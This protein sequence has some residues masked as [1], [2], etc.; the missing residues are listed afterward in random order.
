MMIWHTGIL[1]IASWLVPQEQRAE[2]LAEWQGELWQLRRRKTDAAI[3][4]L[5][6]FRDAMWLW[7]NHPE[8][9][10]CRWPRLEAPS[11]CLFFLATVA[12]LSL[13]F[14]LRLPHIPDP[15]AG[16][17]FS[18]LPPLYNFFGL[19]TMACFVLPVTTSLSLGEYPA[20]RYWL[21]R[22]AFL[23]AKIA[24]VLAPIYSGC[25]YS[26]Y[27]Y[28]THQPSPIPGQFLLLGC[29]LAFRWILNDQRRRCPVC[30]QSLGHAAQVGQ[31]ARNF[32][33][34]NGTELMCKRG[35][36]LL[37]VPATP[38]DWSSRQR[39]LDLDASWSG[40]FPTTHSRSRIS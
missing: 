19:I 28:L 6:S 24:L 3:F 14:V 36:G 32:L 34:W 21:R 11:H 40:L 8:S 9:R 10:R 12:A 22:W 1:N 31:P 13:L 27:Q 18:P 23:A 33:E 20:S 2:W 37:H 17:R 30:L 39:W 4:C 5:G 7:R 25:V 26:K 38:S 16:A 15:R 29:I 35:H